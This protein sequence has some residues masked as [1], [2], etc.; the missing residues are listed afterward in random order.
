MTKN[1]SKRL[2]SGRFLYTLA[3][4]KINAGGKRYSR[5]CQRKNF[6]KEI[7]FQTMLPDYAAILFRDNKSE[8][9]HYSPQTRD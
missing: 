7:L 1:E 3:V 4:S 8:P 2:E 6:V 9:T 5:L